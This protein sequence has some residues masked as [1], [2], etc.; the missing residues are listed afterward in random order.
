M[1]ERDF[2]QSLERGL[3][4]L[5]AFDVDN[6]AMTLSEAA[7]RTGMTRAAARRFLLTLVH[8]QFVAT[9][10]KRF[11][12]RPTVLDLGYRYLAGQPWWHIAQPMVEEM[13]RNTHES[14]SVCVLDGPDVVYVC[15]AAV[16]RIV[17][18]N[19]VIGSRLPA[20]STAL[21]RALLSRL[22]DDE[23]KARLDESRI[24]SSTPAT[25]TS[26]P[27]LLELIREVRTRGYCLLD[28]ELDLDLR[29]LAIPLALPSETVLAAV[30]MSVQATRVSADDL[31]KRYLPVLT[32]GARRI[33]DGVI[34][35]Q[36]QKGAR[37]LAS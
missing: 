35:A 5:K 34:E 23:I 27:R 8:L 21:G 16:S 25:V 18:A 3:A 12:L 20:Y 28:Q 4:V 37:T 26:K 11:W 24:E 19:I 2:V 15:R 9:D 36:R 13:A 17:A 33:R 1:E 29:A 10:G 14:C 32:E 7:A 22:P 6:P 31:V 30:G